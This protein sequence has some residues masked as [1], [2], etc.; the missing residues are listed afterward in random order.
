MKKL[1]FIS[2]LCLI[3]LSLSAQNYVDLGLSSG[4]KWKSANEKG[5]YS[6]GHA[7]ICFGKC[8][9]SQE[10]WM[11]LRNECEWKW[12]G[13]GYKVTGSNGKSIIL[14]AVGYQDCNGTID[15]VGSGGS[16]WSSTPK[17]SD[18]AWCLY[19]V[20]NEVGMTFGRLCGGLSVRLV[21]TP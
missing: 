15:Y 21:Q 13:M 1:L 8:L 12:T 4:T 20:S 16:Y 19:F 3:T 18:D 6:Y 9:P 10:Q 11:E 7:M 5:M 17:D 2:A 14:P